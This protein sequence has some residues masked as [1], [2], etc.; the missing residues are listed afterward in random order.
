M[1]KCLAAD[2][3]RILKQKRFYIYQVLIFVI[4]IFTM[5]GYSSIIEHYMNFSDPAAVFGEVFQMPVFVITT[6]AA[7]FE[8]PLVYA[9]DF[10]SNVMQMAVGRGIGRL[11]YML[12]KETSLMIL[13]M[14]NA[15]MI[16][17][18]GFV[19]S[20]L[21]QT[22]LNGLLFNIIVSRLI[23][24]LVRILAYLSLVQFILYLSGSTSL[25]MFIFMLFC[26]R[27][28]NLAVMFTYM[29]DIPEGVR[30][31][32]SSRLMSTQLEQFGNALYAGRLYPDNIAFIVIW[33]VAFTVLGGL[34]LRR[35]ELSF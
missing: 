21:I 4:T 19:Y 27:I 32:I 14:L 34:V 12:A 3:F 35:K 30:S 24:S 11:K 16:G 2:F 23:A 33:I 22:E 18:A 5:Y 13:A 8:I 1:N 25:A 20:L 15:L 10:H 31:M 6:L 17:L 7:F 28:E 9:D 26:F 29:V